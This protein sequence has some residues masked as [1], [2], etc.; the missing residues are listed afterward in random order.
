MYEYNIIIQPHEDLCDKINAVKKSFAETYQLPVYRFA[1]PHI[2]LVRFSQYEMMEEKIIHRLQNIA[3]SNTAFPIELQDFGSFPTH[4]IFIHVATKNNI[5][6]LV[7]EIKSIQR[8]MKLDNE[9]KPHFITEPFITIAAKL[10]PWQ[11]EKAWLAY[12]NSHFTAMFMAQEMILLK[13]KQGEKKYQTLKRF[14]LLNQKN[15][16]VQPSLFL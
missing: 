13:R 2:C 8:L 7:K 6:V 5:A 16:I 1:K 10:L 3:I 9:H 12:S 15:T 4:S 11:Y 14:Q